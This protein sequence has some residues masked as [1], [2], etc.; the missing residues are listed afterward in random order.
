MHDAALTM[1]AFAGEVQPAVIGLARKLY[2]LANQPFTSRAFVATK[3]VI[4]TSHKPAPAIK[5]S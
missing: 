2:A 1:A 3:R 5:V 4:S